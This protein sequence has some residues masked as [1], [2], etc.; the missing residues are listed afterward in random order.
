[1]TIQ[2]QLQAMQGATFD[3]VRSYGHAR[4]TI[5]ATGDTTFRFRLTDGK[6]VPATGRESDIIIPCTRQGGY[7]GPPEKTVDELL[8]P[9][10]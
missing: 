9:R 3:A 4:Y 7:P 6:A 8:R 1:M 5:D 2:S 10:N